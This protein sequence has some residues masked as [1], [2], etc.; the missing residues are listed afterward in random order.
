[1]LERAF[2]TSVIIIIRHRVDFLRIHP[3]S[4]VLL[5]HKCF[6]DSFLSGWCEHFIELQSAL[7][8]KNFDDIPLLRSRLTLINLKRGGRVAIGYFVIPKSQR[9]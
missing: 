8:F 2:R 1:M 4:H 5:T 9:L 7:D 6:L 3:E